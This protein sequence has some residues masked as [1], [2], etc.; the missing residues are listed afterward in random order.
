MNPQPVENSK[1]L[2]CVSPTTNESYSVDRTY[3]G[4]DYSVRSP[5]IHVSNPDLS[6][7]TAHLNNISSPA[8]QM[9]NPSGIGGDNCENSMRFQLEDVNFIEYEEFHPDKQTS[10]TIR[11]EVSEPSVEQIEFVAINET[12]Q[13]QETQPQEINF[14]QPEALSA[15]DRSE[16]SLPSH[17][18]SHSKFLFPEIEAHRSSVK[19]IADSKSSGSKKC[20]RDYGEMPLKDT[21]SRYD[22]VNTSVYLQ[23]YSKGRFF[24]G[25]IANKIIDREINPA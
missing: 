21:Q 13:L 3:L 2:S 1:I 17:R 20:R 12:I 16:R 6:T 19:S 5:Y 23:E 8:S 15:T 18:P 24:R 9:C 11:Q 22:S 10:T 14:M 25:E 7:R 4:E